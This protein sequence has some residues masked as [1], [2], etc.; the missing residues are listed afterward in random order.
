MCTNHC[1]DLYGHD[2]L[3]PEPEAPVAVIRYN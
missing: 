1:L 2:L 3:V